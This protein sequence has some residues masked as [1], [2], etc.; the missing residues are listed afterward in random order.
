MKTLC[1]RMERCDFP[2]LQE[3]NKLLYF[4]N[5][6]TTLKPKQVIKAIE[7]Y[8][9]REGA[10]VHRGVYDLAQKTT[11][12]QH[13]AR[14]KVKNFIH[15]RSEKEIIFTSGTTASLNLLSFILGE[16]LIEPGDEI[17]I[18]EIEHHSNIVPWQFLV[19][20]KKAVLKT[21]PVLKSADLDLK[22]LKELLTPK[23]KIV[24]LAHISNVF[25]TIHPLE[26]I[27]PM[28]RQFSSALIVVDGAQSVA[29]HPID[30][31]A[32]D[33]DFFAFSAHKMYGPTGLGV[34]YGKEELLKKLPPYQG[35]GDMIDHVLFE[36]TTFNELPYKYEAGTPH[37]AGI[38]GLHAALT[39]LEGLNLHE[40]YAYE[41]ALTTYA[42]KKLEEIDRVKVIG[43]P[44]NRSS[45]LSFIVQGVHPLDLTTLLNFK[46]I[47]LRSGHL[48]AQPALKRFE[49]TS[50]L[51]LSFAPYN[52]FEEIDLF[53]HHLRQA[54]E[55]L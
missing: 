52:S 45:I 17:L 25:G 42:L 39:Y 29:H 33:V 7:H 51:R 18:S 21:I 48:C 4:D 13:Q 22:A 8:Y 44:K 9:A 46:K 28:I 5:A 47:A 36:K 40:M 10:T 43:H 49:L 31:T 34:L 35:G 19:Q 16:A 55:K 26:E 6:A 53:I 1:P 2:M 38:Y 32:L 3:E 50:L 54:L 37:I 24:S 11:E 23:T 12:H 14:I 30:V 27:I 41:H 20:R 15:A